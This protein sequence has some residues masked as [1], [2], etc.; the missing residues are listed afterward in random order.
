[1]DPSIWGESAWFYLH[2]VTLSYPEKPTKQDKLDMYNFFKHLKL[3]CIKCQVN[4][5]KHLKKHP[6]TEKVLSKRER[7]V[8][9]L[10]DIHNEVN[11][12]TGK[13]IMSYEEAITKCLDK[14]K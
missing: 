13:K 3:P 8:K 1:M 7:L 9:W 6:I 12:E 14:H 4:Y 10:I 2:T 5:K 11:I